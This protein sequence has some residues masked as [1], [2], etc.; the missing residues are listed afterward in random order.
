MTVSSLKTDS[1]KNFIV[2]ILGKERQNKFVAYIA[3]I[4]M[5]KTKDWNEKEKFLISCATEKKILIFKDVKISC[6]NKV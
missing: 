2:Q 3:H 4:D 6:R 5:L 1:T